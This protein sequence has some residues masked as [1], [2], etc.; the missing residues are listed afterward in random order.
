MDPIIFRNNL[1]IAAIH[2]EDNP[3]RCD[4]TQL[5]VTFEFLTEPPVKTI[6]SSLICQSPANVSGYSWEAA[7]FDI[8]NVNVY[9]SKDKT[10]GMVMVSLLILVV[11]CGSVVS[12]KHTMK[13]KRRVLEQRQ[14]LEM[15]ERERLRLLYR[16]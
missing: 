9:Y 8:W 7:C 14:H 1:D 13:I 2:L 4:C 15:A 12:I 16:R 10:W 3:W 6:G 5:Y 11:F